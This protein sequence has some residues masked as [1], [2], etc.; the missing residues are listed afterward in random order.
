MVTSDSAVSVKYSWVSVPLFPKSFGRAG[1]AV[2]LNPS[3]VT[4]PRRAMIPAMHSQQASPWKN[5]L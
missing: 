1:E 4:K 5:L 3:F 2:L